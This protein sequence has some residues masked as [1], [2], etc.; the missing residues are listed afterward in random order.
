[1]SSGEERAWEILNSLELSSVCKNASVLFDTCKN[2][3]SFERWISLKQFIDGIAICKHVE[4][5]I[6]RDARSFYARLT[7]ANPWINRYPFNHCHPPP[8]VSLSLYQNTHFFYNFKS[9]HQRQL[10]APAG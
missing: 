7:V 3:L 6:D 9:R 10:H 1:M 8:F 2:I 4:N 5:L